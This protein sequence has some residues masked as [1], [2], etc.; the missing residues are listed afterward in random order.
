MWS[1]ISSSISTS[2]CMFIKRLPLPSS[3][4]GVEYESNSRNVGFLFKLG[5]FLFFTLFY[6]LSFC[7]K[8][9]PVMHVMHHAT[10]PCYCTVTSTTSPRQTIFLLAM[11]V[12][13]YFCSDNSVVS[14]NKNMYI[15]NSALGY[16][17]NT[18]SISILTY[19]GYILFI[20]ETLNCHINL[21]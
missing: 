16:I 9:L 15:F 13:K 18:S 6:G 20:L 7:Q 17:T 3:P 12:H 19:S 10:A 5:S 2:S 21:N 4:R 11:Y 1:L 8:Q 14:L